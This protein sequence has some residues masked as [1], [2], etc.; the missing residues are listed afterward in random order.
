MFAVVGLTPCGMSTA[1]ASVGTTFTIPF[2][3]YDTGLPHLGSTVYRAI[4]VIPPC[5]SG[6]ATHHLLHAY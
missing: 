5:P 6:Q 2:S 3:V 4:L 1:T